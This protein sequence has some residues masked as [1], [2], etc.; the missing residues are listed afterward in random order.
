MS[1]STSFQCFTLIL[2]ILPAII[3]VL[4]FM[5]AFPHVPEAIVIHPSLSSLSKDSR[6]WQI[7]PENI[8]SGGAYVSFPYGRVRYWLLGPED[9]IKV[10]FSRA[11][12]ALVAEFN[13]STCR[14]CSYMVSQ[15]HL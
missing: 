7:Y 13:I 8:F 6:S 9:G 2:L 1:P 14:L 4:Y 12:I 11:F 10:H 15:S 3:L 5:T